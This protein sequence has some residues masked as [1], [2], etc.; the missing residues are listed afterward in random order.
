MYAHPTCPQV[1]A[2]TQLLNGSGVPYT[3][4]NIHED[5]AG[6]ERV[7]QI[8]NG[9]ESVPTLVFADGSTLTE[10]ST[11]ELR[12][13]LSRLGYQVPLKDRLLANLPR[14]LFI[15]IILWAVLEFLEII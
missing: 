14:L 9:Y 5:R 12:K 10:P 3:Y 8:N 7:R 15:G 1:P 2:V 6:R 4:I 13:K 11:P